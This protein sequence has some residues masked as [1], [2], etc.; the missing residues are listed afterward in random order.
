MRVLQRSARSPAGSDPIHDPPSSSICRTARRA[1]SYGAHQ[2]LQPCARS[3]CSTGTVAGAV[4]RKQTL[5]RAQGSTDTAF[6]SVGDS[7]LSSD[8][9]E[10]IV[11]PEVESLQPLIGKRALATLVSE[12][13]RALGFLALPLT[14][15]PVY[16][17]HRPYLQLRPATGQSCSTF[18]SPG[19]QQRP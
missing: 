11:Q 18:W 6:I 14:A 13:H 1:A 16:M 17:L 12:R 8:E 7:I 19:V 10:L 3:A 5:T 2:M 15:E 4:A 9:E